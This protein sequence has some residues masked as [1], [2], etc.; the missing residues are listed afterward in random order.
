MAVFVVA[1]DLNAIG[2]NYTCITAKLGGLPHCHAQGSVWFVEYAGTAGE[3][4]AYLAPCLDSNDKLFVD[5]VSNTWAG[6]GMPTCGQ[7]LNQRGL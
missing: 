4:R 2:Q 6:W 5:L 7:W 1:Y 3:L